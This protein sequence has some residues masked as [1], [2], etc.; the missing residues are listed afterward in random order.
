MA[1]F[2]MGLVIIAVLSQL[3]AESILPNAC[4][5]PASSYTSERLSGCAFLEDGGYH[6]IRVLPS[7]VLL[8]SGLLALRRQRAK[9]L[10]VGFSVAF[11]LLVA[12]IFVS[13]D[14]Y[15]WA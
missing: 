11:T 7:L 9:M 4:D 8:G 13:P 15:L 3:V 5:E 2:A 14:S 10:L 12:A 1:L 6:A